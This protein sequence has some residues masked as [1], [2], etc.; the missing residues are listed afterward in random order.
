ML[1]NYTSLTAGSLQIKP[2]VPLIMFTIYIPKPIEMLAMSFVRV[3]LEFYI[4]IKF[5]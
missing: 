1:T 4:F 2:T 5:S 3:N